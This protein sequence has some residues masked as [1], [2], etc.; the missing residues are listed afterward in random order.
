MADG[1]KGRREAHTPADFRQSGGSGGA[2]GAEAGPTIDPR[3]LA[4]ALAAELDAAEGRQPGLFEDEAPELP[5]DLPIRG[6]RSRLA[7]PRGRGRPLG[8]GNKRSELMRDTLLK[9]GFQH[10]MVVLAGV[11]SASPEEVA[12]ELAGGEQEWRSC[13]AE[14]RRDLLDKALKHITGAATA[15]LPYFESKRPAEVHVQEDRRHLFLVGQIETAA[16]PGGALSL[17]GGNGK[18]FDVQGLTD[19]EDMR[20]GDDTSHDDA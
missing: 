12:A 2:V 20:G 7:S 9:L 10:P 17:G 14:T 8:A 1:K 3:P 6:T 15:L 19:G 4:D 13:G 11:A 18:V 5:I 16:G